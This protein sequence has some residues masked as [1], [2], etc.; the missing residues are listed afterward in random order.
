MVVRMVV[1]ILPERESASEAENRTRTRKKTN[2][3]QEGGK[4]QKA[5][6]SRVGA[7]KQK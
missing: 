7:R 1:G 5:N 3:K 4:H 2:Q 6:E